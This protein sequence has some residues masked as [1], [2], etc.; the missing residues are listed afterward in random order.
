MRR[1]SPK[2]YLF[3]K[4]LYQN[5]VVNRV[6]GSIKGGWKAD[7][8]KCVFINFQKVEIDVAVLNIA[9]CNDFQR[10]EPATEN[11]LESCSS[12]LTL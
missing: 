12:S 4:C 3:K 9:T 6:P 11:A 2:R 8:N 7:S 10:V 1:D 5:K